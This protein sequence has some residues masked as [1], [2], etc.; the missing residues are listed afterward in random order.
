MAQQAAL[1]REQEE[2][3]ALTAAQATL[4]QATVVRQQVGLRFDLSFRWNLCC[5]WDRLVVTHV[6]G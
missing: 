1:W 5:V 2:A 4:A 3:A 6:H